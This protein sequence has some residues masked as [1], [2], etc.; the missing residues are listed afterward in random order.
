[1]KSAA[2]LGTWKHAR[3]CRRYAA[4]PRRSGCLV[5]PASI[6]AQ[7]SGTNSAMAIHH[8]APAVEA[9]TLFLHL[10]SMWIFLQH[11]FGRIDAVNIG[12]GLR[13]TT[14]MAAPKTHITTREVYA[15][16][17][18]LARSSPQSRTSRRDCP[19]HVYT[20]EQEPRKREGLPE[21]AFVEPPN[22][23]SNVLTIKPITVELVV[24]VYHWPARV[25]RTRPSHLKSHVADVRNRTD[26][27]NRAVAVASN[28][29]NHIQDHRVYHISRPRSSPRRPLP[30][31]STIRGTTDVWEGRSADQTACL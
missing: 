18:M 31:L 21:Q 13:L 14:P 9:R 5:S 12:G 6:D 8:P 28:I 24:M 1:M 22:M 4:V 29:D 20:Q 2:R 7:H 19:I 3:T 23:S 10:R 17:K 11:P 26:S 27:T 15:A 30:S 25:W 16:G